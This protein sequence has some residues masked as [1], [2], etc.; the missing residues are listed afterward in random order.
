MRFNRNQLVPPQIRVI[1][2]KAYPVIL[3][4]LCAYPPLSFAKRELAVHS[5]HMVP[6]LV[7]CAL[8]LGCT[9]AGVRLLRKHRGAFRGAALWSILLLA[10]A[11]EAAYPSSQGDTPVKLLSVMTMACTLYL[12]YGLLGKW[13][14]ILLCAMLCLLT[15]VLA[16]K[17]SYGV[18]IDASIMSQLIGASPQDVEQFATPGAIILSLASL[19]GIVLAGMAMAR[20]QRRQRPIPLLWLGIGTAVPTILSAYASITPCISVEAQCMRTPSMPFQLSQAYFLAKAKN[21]AFVK[22]ANSLPSPADQPSSISTLQGGEGVIC[23]L[24]IGESVRADHLPFNG[25]RR[26]TMPWVAQQANLVNYP[27]CIACAPYT[28][29]STFSLLTNGRGVASSPTVSPELHASTGSVMDLFHKHGFDCRCFFNTVADRNNAGGA[30]YEAIQLALTKSAD[31]MYRLTGNYDPKKQLPQLA[32]ATRECKGKNAFFLIN[33]LGS[34]IP[35]NMYDHAKPAFAPASPHAAG[36]SP[37]SNP[38]AATETV[39]AYDSTITYTDEYIHALMDN[40][41]GLP[42]IY[43]YISDHGEPLGDNGLWTRHCTPQEYHKTQ[44]CKV[45]FFI[46]YSP[47]FE[48]MHPHFAEA[49]QNLRRN[50]S[51]EVGH[52]HLFHTLLGIFG[53]CTPY[54]EPSLDLSSEGAAPHSGPSPSR[55]GKSADGLNWM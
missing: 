9:A 29:E 8:A 6:R 35:F 28:T 23:L 4:L 11:C 1:L 24:H 36:N 51:M 53:I 38:T 20:L 14:S 25:Y 22:R 41:Q 3:G 16:A 54:Y 47:E 17:W 52:E 43:I 5:T 31:K 42:Y 13:A 45:G 55:G 48:Q 32:V 15:C 19:C 37:E 33:N 34:H 2:S 44:W 10:T 27:S 18:D 21:S 50:S 7:L 46:L 39:N 49:L 12:L 30:V 26:Q 40:M